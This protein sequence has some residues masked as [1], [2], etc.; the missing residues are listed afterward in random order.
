MQIVYLGTED[1]TLGKRDGEGKAIIKGSVIEQLLLWA[2]EL[3]LTEETLRAS[4]YIHLKKSSTNPY[5]SLV[6]D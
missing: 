2:T 6:E 3:N 5:W 4:V 1:R